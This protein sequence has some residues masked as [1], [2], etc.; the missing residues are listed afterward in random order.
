M[1][2]T[3]ARRACI[4]ALFAVLFVPAT[5]SSAEKAIWGSINLPNGDSAFPS[6]LA[7]SCG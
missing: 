3:T 1:H 6:L 7:E 2:S 5:A 4:L